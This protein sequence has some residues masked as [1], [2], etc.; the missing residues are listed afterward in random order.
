MLTNLVDKTILNQAALFGLLTDLDLPKLF[1][2]R[3][4]LFLI[5]RCF[6]MVGDGI[7]PAAATLTCIIAGMVFYCG[8][9]LGVYPATLLA[10]KFRAGKVCASLV[11]VWSVAEILLLPTRIPKAWATIHR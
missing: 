1:R 7:E 6:H 9:I 3:A 11:L 2:S 10:Q 5:R 8:Y 4:E